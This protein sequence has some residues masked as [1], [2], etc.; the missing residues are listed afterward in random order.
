LIIVLLLVGFAIYGGSAWRSEAGITLFKATPHTP[1]EM[2]TIVAGTLIV[3][4]GFETTRY[5][6][7]EFKA[8]I[9]V[10]ASRWSQII[11]TS[12]YLLFIAAGICLL[13]HV[14]MPGGYKREQVN[15]STDRY[16][17]HC[18]CAW[19]HN[20]FRGTRELARCTPCIVILT[21][22]S[23]SYWQISSQSAR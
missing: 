18:D 12:V 13:L 11:S 2:L 6:G 1:W 10:S 14:A 3:V 9:R 4:Q 23:S 20:D 15:L 19:L 21:H 8:N 7:D 22:P 16:G 5:L 17:G